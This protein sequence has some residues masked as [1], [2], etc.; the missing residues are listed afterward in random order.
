MDPKLIKAGGEAHHAAIAGVGAGGV[1]S[2]S[3]LTAITAALGRM[4]ASVP[5]SKTM[6]VYNSVS[7]KLSESAY[8]LIKD[9]DWTSQLFSK[10]IPGKSPA[11]AMKAIDKMIV[12]GSSMDGVARQEAA[13]AHVKAI[14]GV[15][16]KGVLSSSDFQAINSA[17]GKAIATVP[18]SQVMDVYNEMSK[19]VG[20]SSVPNYLYSQ[21][22]P[23]DAQAAYNALLQ[24]K[25]VVKA[26]R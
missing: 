9:V 18:T 13:A 19:F 21:V 8:P 12:M 7:S 25:D 5:E 20:T 14:N 1:C 24:F 15:D 4:I 11:D 26:A 16:A 6:D 2:Q 3:Q 23:G 10:P 17:L 22:N